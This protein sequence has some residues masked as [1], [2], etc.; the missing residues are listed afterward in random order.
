M[1][2]HKTCKNSFHGLDLVGDLERSKRG[3]IPL[4]D[5]LHYANQ[6]IFNEN[7]HMS[8]MQVAMVN[9]LR[10]QSIIFAFIL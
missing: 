3:V 9:P 7:H 8:D 2:S 10:Q 4:G 6:G 1:K 5:E